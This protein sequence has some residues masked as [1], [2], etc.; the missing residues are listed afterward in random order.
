VVS[1]KPDAAETLGTPTQL[2]MALQPFVL[3]PDVQQL[4][5]PSAGEGAAATGAGSSVSR[6]AAA[7]R[8]TSEKAIGAMLSF[9]A[10]P[11]WVRVVN[12]LAC[13]GRRFA[14]RES[15][16]LAS[17][18]ERVAESAPWRRARVPRLGK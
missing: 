4:I 3:V 15:G 7:A 9:I 5:P 11:P 8:V 14:G 10:C 16:N 17:R 18:V 2:M 12:T 13:L 6:A 1:T